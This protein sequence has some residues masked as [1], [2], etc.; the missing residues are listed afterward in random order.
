[1]LARCPLDNSLHKRYDES[2]PYSM[3]TKTRQVRGFVGGVLSVGLVAILCFVSASQHA[4]AA[5]N[6]QI[7]FQGKLTNPDGTNVTNGTYSL[8]FRI[9]NHATNDA[10]NTCSANSCLWEETQASVS[11]ADGIFQVALGSVNTALASNVDFNTSGLYLGIKVGA[12]AEMTP[13]V[14]FTASPYAFNSEKL[15]GISSTGF[16]QIGV[17]AAQTDASTNTAIFLNKTSTGNQLQLQASGVDVFTVSNSGNLTLGQNAAKTISVAQRSTNAAGQSLTVVAGQGGAGAAANAGGELILQGGA[18]GGTNGVGGNLTLAGGAGSGT[19]AS[20]T[21]LVKNPGNSAV[22]FQVQD[23]SSAAMFT[24]DSTARSAS[25]GNL[26]KIGNSTGTDTALTILQLDSTTA[27]PTSNLAALN[28]GLFYNSTT[29]KVN[30]IENG[31]VKALC[32][33]TDLG[34]GAGG[35]GSTLQAAYTASTNPE[36]TL[37]STRGALTIRDNSSAISGNLFEVQNNA[38]STTYLGITSS[39]LTLGSNVGFTMTGSSAFISNAQGTTSSSGQAFGLNATAA[40]NAVALGTQAAVSND[41]VAIGYNASTASPG[42]IAIG[43]EAATNGNNQFV[44]GSNAA[45][46]TDVYFG[47]GITDS[48]SPSS[49]TFNASG[50]SGTNIAGANFNIAGG[51]GT[52][53]GVGGNINLQI[54]TPSGSSGTTAN[55]LASVATISGTN[56]SALFKNSADSTTAFQVQNSSSV[57]ILSVDTTAGDAVNIG[58]VAN[59]ANLNV[60]VG[61]ASQMKVT[62]GAVPT[63]DMVNISN[64]GQGVTTAGVNG[65]AINYVGGAAA[66]EGGAQRIDY[67]PGGTTGGTWNG[68][69]IVANTTGAATGVASNGVK[70]EGPT[71]AG[72]GT[73]T[74]VNITTGWDIGLHIESGG[75]QLASGTDPAAP[76][77]GDL[78]VYARTIAGRTMLKSKGSSGVDY[79]LQPSLFQQSVLL[80][81]PGN[82]TTATTWSGTGGQLAAGGTLSMAAST[83]AQGFMGNVATA[84]TAGTGAGVS[85]AT[86]QYY[87]G[88]GGNNANGFFFF[89]RVNFPGAIATY[90]DAAAGARVFIGLSS[91][92]IIGAGAMASSDNPTGDYAGFQFA[93]AQSTTSFRFMTKDNVTQSAANIGVTFAVAKTYDFYIYCKPGDSTIYWRVDNQ[94]DGTAPVEGTV[95]ANLPRTTIAMRAGVAIAPLNTTADNIRIQRIYV[96]T[97]R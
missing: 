9:Y 90:N 38:G 53:T 85:N 68:L 44:A 61:G 3:K 25:G 11:V 15:G 75:I 28:G 49:V 13:R 31:T 62:A 86:T 93:P 72:A 95:T 37:D 24:V 33:T 46:I 45:P 77:S 5:I 71:V 22:A 89:A 10:A 74:A 84:T 30:I 55:A 1:L 92:N 50:G 40:N 73:D 67:A 70:L 27:A 17:A 66:V 48:T 65:L 21:V 94:T 8:R 20:G 59:A 23:A 52:G 64:A 18:G 63:A 39:T 12:D 2:V 26:I 78:K 47:S 29:G 82:G 81:T 34:C 60:N 36:I 42:G 16:A 88:S 76:A 41:G 69:R 96:E 58:T 14:Q 79:A 57:A 19:G 91:A 83:E 56:G 7:N 4:S 80:I 6:Q 43:R 97:D 32:N 51:R 87:R 35:G 54:A